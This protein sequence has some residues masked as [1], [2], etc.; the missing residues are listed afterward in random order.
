LEFHN[1]HRRVIQIKKKKKRGTG[2]ETEEEAHP[3]YTE[4]QTVIRGKK[5]NQLPSRHVK[6]AQMKKLER[7]VRGTRE[8]KNDSYSRLGAIQ[9]R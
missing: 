1:K 7:Q 3:Q 6:G 4:K 2:A 5:K 9:W 8:P